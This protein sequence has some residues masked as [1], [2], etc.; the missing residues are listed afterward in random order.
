MDSRYRFFLRWV[1]LGL[2]VCRHMTSLLRSGCLKLVGGV[3]KRQMVTP[4]DFGNIWALR[5]I[6]YLYKTWSLIRVQQSKWVC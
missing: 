6:I 3:I 5:F 4:S 2:K 1:Y